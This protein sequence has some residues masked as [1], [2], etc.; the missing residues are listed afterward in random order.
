MLM[1]VRSCT[2]VH[3]FVRRLVW[4][5]HPGTFL[6]RITQCTYRFFLY[7]NS[8]WQYSVSCK[9]IYT[10]HQVIRHHSVNIFV[11][12][13][14]FLIFFLVITIFNFCHYS[15]KGKILNCQ[16]IQYSLLKSLGKQ[17]LKVRKST[18]AA[19]FLVKNCHQGSQKAHSFS[20]LLRVASY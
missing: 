11:F 18:N 20:A 17:P 12:W 6:S 14:F 1:Y 16:R 10:K 15:F 19:A 3:Y 8:F 5:S 2:G 4:I 13:S 7:E 9:V